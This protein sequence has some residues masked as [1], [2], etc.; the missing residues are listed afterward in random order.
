MIRTKIARFVI[1]RAQCGSCYNEIDEKNNVK[2]GVFW[3]KQFASVE[4]SCELS[5]E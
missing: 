3:C 5:C 2:R 4:R 1:Y